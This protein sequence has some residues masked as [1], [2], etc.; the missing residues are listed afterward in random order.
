MTLVERLKK[1]RLLLLDV[2]GV[3][4]DGRITLDDNNVQ[5]KAF[6]VTDGHGLKMIQR[7]GVEVG[8]ITGR[9][10]RVV[11]HRAKELGIEIV[12][13]GAKDKLV[14]A[15]QILSEKGIKPDEVAYIG[16]DIVDLPVML[17]VGLAATVADAR[18]EVKSRAHWVID[19][20]GGRGAVREFCD[21]LLKAKGEWEALTKRYFEPEPL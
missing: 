7:V 1:V 11:E 8:I 4:T 17:Q 2:D 12:H 10:S 15:R 9:T 16:D 13:Q 14:V 21:T 3:L 19:I 18:E 6:D 20:P 5:S